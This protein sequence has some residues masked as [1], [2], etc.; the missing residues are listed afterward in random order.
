MFTCPCRLFN[1]RNRRSIIKQEAHGPHRSP[2]K[3]VQINKHDYIITLIKRRKK[4]IINFMRIYWFFIW[5]NLNPLHP[6]ML[7]AKIVWN[8]LSGSGEEDFFYFVFDV[9]LLFRNYLPLEKGV[10]LHL[11]KL[12]SPFTQGCFVPS[13]VEIGP[14]VLEEKIFKV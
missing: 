4:N 14:V 7:C 2:E 1:N 3:T 12:K 8:W 11:Y 13:L 9:F 10:V 6:K 5:R